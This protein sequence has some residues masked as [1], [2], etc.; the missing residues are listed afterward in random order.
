M[1]SIGKVHKDATTLAHNK[2]LYKIKIT[3]VY[4]NQYLQNRST[5]SLIKSHMVQLN[6]NFNNETYI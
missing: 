1:L 3:L 4:Y 2:A 6:L 5:F